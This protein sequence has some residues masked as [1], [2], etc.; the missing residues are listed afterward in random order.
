LAGTLS[1]PGLLIWKNPE[2]ALVQLAFAP[3]K[4]PVG[5]A[6]Q[7]NAGLPSVVVDQARAFSDA[8][9]HDF[10]RLATGRADRV[11]YLRRQVIS[12][13][14]SLDSSQCDPDVIPPN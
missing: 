6:P 3:M 11:L 13:H 12:V 14:R 4:L 8:C 7:L 5:R 1:R 10:Q 2:L 9:I